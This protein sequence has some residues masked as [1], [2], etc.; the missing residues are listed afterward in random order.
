MLRN[1]G[2]ER[3][4]RYGIAYANA[5]TVERKDRPSEKSSVKTGRTQRLMRGIVRACAYDVKIGPSENK[6]ADAMN[7]PDVRPYRARRTRAEQRDLHEQAVRASLRMFE[8]G[9]Y[10]ALS[11]RKLASQVG[12]PPMSLYR[13]FPTKA[14]LIR[15]IWADLLLR[16]H[17]QATAALPEA[18]DA[19][20]RLAAYLDAWLQYWLDNRRHYWVVFAI[21]DSGRDWVAETDGAA[22]RPDPWRVLATLSELVDG[23]VAEGGRSRLHPH[24]VEVLFCKTLGFLT[25]VIGMASLAKADVDGLKRSLVAEMVEQVVSGRAVALQ[26]ENGGA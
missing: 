5:K 22:P 7:A 8:D 24:A 2:Q 9:G 10:E 25:G 16:A 14:H 13:Y 12:V 21:R 6:R 4:K 15:H 3:R 23:C 20:M 1:G 17:S 19:P 26:A 18:A 11:M